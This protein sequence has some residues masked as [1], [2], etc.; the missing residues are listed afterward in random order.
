MNIQRLFSLL[1]SI[2]AIIVISSACTETSPE[3]PGATSTPETTDTAAEPYPDPGAAAADTSIEEAYPGAGPSAPEPQPTVVF[4]IPTPTSQGGVI[5]GTMHD[6]T[7]GEAFDP[8]SARGINVYLAE[9]ITSERGLSEFATLDTST[10]PTSGLDSEGA[11]VFS[12]V[13]PGRYA[14]VIDT[15][16]AQRMTQV[17]PDTEEDVLVTVE[18]GEAVDVG[19]VYAQF[20]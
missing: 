20:P 1:A 17:A 16:V 5:H 10:A 6:F 9:I 19:T 3:A 14:I 11:F 8:V 4:V 12:D 7:T 2:C 13:E 18:S 15:P